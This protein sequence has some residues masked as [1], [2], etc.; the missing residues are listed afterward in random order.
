MTVAS[1]ASGAVEARAQDESAFHELETKYIFGN[2][3][4]GSATGIEGEVA[5]EPEISGECRIGDE[6]V[7]PADLKRRGKPPEDR[8]SVVGDRGRLAVHRL[9]LHDRPSP[10]LDEG[11]VAEADAE[12]RHA[13]LGEPP[14]DL[15]RLGHPAPGPGELPDGCEDLVLGGA[16]G[17]HRVVDG[18]LTLGTFVAFMAYRDDVLA[19]F[20]IWVQHAPGSPEASAGEPAP[21]SST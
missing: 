7:I 12:R 11:L 6:R 10:A 17:G 18:S 3:T 4:V 5:I 16:E 8:L 14:H 2:F 9:V 13:R 21:Q 20:P 1:T 19:S 15:E